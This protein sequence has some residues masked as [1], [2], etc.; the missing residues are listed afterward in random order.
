MMTGIPCWITSQESRSNGA[1]SKS[2]D[3]QGDVEVLAFSWRHFWAMSS[4]CGEG[5]SKW[6]V[7]LWCDARCVLLTGTL[8]FST[9]SRWRPFSPRI[10]GSHMSKCIVQWRTCSFKVSSYIGSS[11]LCCYLYFLSKPWVRVWWYILAIPVLERW[12]PEDQEFKVIVN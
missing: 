6:L 4:R 1:W 2:C 8:P 11:P 5:I 10:Q 9:L 12:R 3:P 7:S